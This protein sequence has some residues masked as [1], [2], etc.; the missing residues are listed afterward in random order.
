[1]EI[2]AWVTF[3]LTVT[4]SVSNAY[5]NSIFDEDRGWTVR[6]LERSGTPFS[7]TA[8]KQ[9]QNVRVGITPAL[10]EDDSFILLST[11]IRSDQSLRSPHLEIMFDQRTLLIP[12][13][14]I[15]IGSGEVI[16]YITLD[17]LSLNQFGSTQAL[18]I[19]MSPHTRVE[20]DNPQYA[21][22][23]LAECVRTIAPTVHRSEMTEVAKSKFPNVIDSIPIARAPKNESDRKTPP[24]SSI[25]DWKDRSKKTLPKNFQNFVKVMSITDPDKIKF[26]ALSEARSKYNSNWIDAGWIG[27]TRLVFGIG[28]LTEAKS[29]DV[30]GYWANDR[31]KNCE[32][33]GGT[34]KTKDLG[35]IRTNDMRAHIGYTLCALK[36]GWLA[37]S[38][39][40]YDMQS[41]S[42]GITEANLYDKT[43]KKFYLYT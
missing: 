12:R 13:E 36:D 25:S 29:K 41:K 21:M 19:N 5:A 37:L 1:M 2:L 11:T 22:Y 33:M 40:A 10:I 30:I 43:H 23:L 20:L 28:Y 18:Q 32:S 42:F 17:D 34:A 3:A 8:E 15:K 6:T 14:H 38:K 4:L 39:T 35:V 26:L 16:L 9:I 24:A 27:D 31:K 7:C